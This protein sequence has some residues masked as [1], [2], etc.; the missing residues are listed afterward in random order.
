MPENTNAGP[1]PAELK[2]RAE[3]LPDHP[4]AT[5]GASSDGDEGTATMPAARSHN[6]RPA[7]EIG[8]G[9]VDDVPQGDSGSP[10]N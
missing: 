3:S 7:E 5:P 1:S 8:D 4:G 10:S 9:A 6:E 2:E